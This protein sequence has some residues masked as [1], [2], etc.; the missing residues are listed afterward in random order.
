MGKEDLTGKDVNE[1]MEYYKEVAKE[2]IILRE[3]WNKTHDSTQAQ[4]LYDE[5]KKRK[6]N[7]GYKK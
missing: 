7:N 6:E 3:I 2:G 5:Y 4:A 1:K